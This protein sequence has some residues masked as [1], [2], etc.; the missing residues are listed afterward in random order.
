VTGLIAARMA[1]YGESARE[2]ADALLAKARAQTI[3][4]V[5]PVLFPGCGGEERCDRCGGGDGRC[6]GCGGRCGGGCG[7][8][9]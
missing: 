6:G 3:P 4:G 1:R 9:G 2:A 7:C 5:G 8:G